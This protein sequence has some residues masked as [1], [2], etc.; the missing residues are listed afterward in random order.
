MDVPGRT[1]LVQNKGVAKIKGRGIIDRQ[2]SCHQNKDAIIA[3]GL[4]ITSSSRKVVLN[5]GECKARQFLDDCLLT[6]EFL[7]FEGEAGVICKHGCELRS[8]GVV[9]TIVVLKELGCDCLPPETQR[10]KSTLYA[11]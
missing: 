6:L 2:D 9:Q 3:S 1:I 5:A 7:A 10:F 8:V 11:D 4:D